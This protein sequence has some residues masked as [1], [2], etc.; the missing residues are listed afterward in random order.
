MMYTEHALTF[1]C[2]DMRLHGIASVP[3]HPAVRGILIIVG[4][5]Q[6]RAGSHRQFTLI[7]RALAL[8]GIPVFRFDYRGMG[9][10]EGALRTFEDIHHDIRAAIDAFMQM[11]PSLEEIIIWGLCDAAS[12]ALFYGHQDKRV[13]GLVLINPWARTQQGIAR[14]YLK[15][16]YLSRLLA[17]DFWS[18]VLHGRFRYSEAFHSMITQL[19]N[20][21]FPQRHT[22]KPS[23]VLTASS[24][25]RLPPLP[26]RLYE[27]LAK[28]KG[29]VLIILSGNDLTAQEFAELSCSSRKWRK[30]L[31]APRVCRKALA[32]A[33]HTFSRRVWRDQVVQWTGDWMKTW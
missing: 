9:D 22:A 12:A 16:Y 10:S 11:T 21:C 5:P 7:A 1:Q 24:T 29:R 3:P 17:S 14:T 33:N 18:N 15:H 6:Y 32:G 25:A 13:K 20:A 2:E 4:G 31:T 28:F 8:R 26:D 19:R 23:P 30:L 27:G